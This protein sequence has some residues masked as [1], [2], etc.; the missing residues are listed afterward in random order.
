MVSLPAVIVPRYFV[1][2]TVI[3]PPHAIKTTGPSPRP[4]F[5]E[6][7]KEID[8]FFEKRGKV[9]KTMRRLAQR[10]EKAG[11]AYAIVGGMAVNAHGHRRTT[12]DVDFLL[13][14]A[15]FAEFQRR[16]L[17]KNYQ[18]VPG[19]PRRFTH[20]STVGACFWRRNRSFPPSLPLP[21][22]M[23]W[24]GVSSSARRTHRKSI[25]RLRSGMRGSMSL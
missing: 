13:T 3:P 22:W 9:H 25:L 11:I 2:V 14:A 20:S 24:H 23:G 10:L 18:Q 16:F 21:H 1:K 6:R 4:R 19:R 12:A 15:G 8:M 17:P 7:L 5:R